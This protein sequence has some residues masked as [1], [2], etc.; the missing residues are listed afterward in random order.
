MFFDNLIKKGVPMGAKIKLD[1]LPSELQTILGKKATRKQTSI[2]VIKR[3]AIQSLNAISSLS[4]GD[5]DRAL[6]LALKMNK[7]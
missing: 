1:D 6:K 7:G 5:R 3:S 4:T 2:E